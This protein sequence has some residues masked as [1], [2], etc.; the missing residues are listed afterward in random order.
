MKKPNR[1]P[2]VTKKSRSSRPAWLR[3][4]IYTVFL[5]AVMAIECREQVELEPASCDAPSAEAPVPFYTPIYSFFLNWASKDSH[6]NVSVISIEAGLDEVQQ[7]LCKGRAYTADLIRAVA[8]QQPSAIVIDKFY[9]P[10]ACD[11]N[12]PY[13][14]ELTK[15]IRSLSIPVIIGASTDKPE[16]E[17]HESCLIEKKQFD[18]GTPNVHYGLIRLNSNKEQIPL[19]WPVLPEGKLAPGEKA[20]L[21]D[22]LALTV[23]KIAAPDV[24]AHARFQE[25]LSGARQP[26]GRL[27]TPLHPQKST[28]L[29][30]TVG[31]AAMKERW[32]P[33]CSDD[34]SEP[35]VTVDLRGKVV[36]IG[37]EN[38]VDHPFALGVKTYGFILQAH[39]IDSLISG[40][41]LR[42]AT[43]V[44]T[45]GL[46][47]FFLC[48]IEIVPMIGE[49]FYCK[50]H[51]D[52]PSL[53]L[54]ISWIVA[55]GI[56]FFV[57]MVLISLANHYLPPP[58][59]IF[60]IVMAVA[61]R[62]AFF[63]LERSSQSLIAE[64][65]EK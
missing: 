49:H 40:N 4:A 9:S 30:C 27:D 43:A 1:S 20:P 46:F 15:V 54:Y 26:Y 6:S 63:G 32:K 28:K 8:E 7:N 58:L 62:I 17:T 33:H 37:A 48:V 60:G 22:S 57:L 56:V 39:Y 55:L 13:T 51:G 64:K 24:V 10:T 59:L 11:S 34:K 12:D 31:T 14:K 45:L 18:F 44:V 19:Q 35:D 42:A 5:I 3:G 25:L 23:A 47:L 50:K 36:V 41:Y 52:E 16:I 29:L 65:K 21:R 38:E 53:P 2:V 61:T